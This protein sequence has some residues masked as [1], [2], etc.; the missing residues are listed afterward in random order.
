MNR[1]FQ[2]L[3]WLL[4]RSQTAL[5]AAMPRARREAQLESLP[6]SLCGAPA[7]GW[8]FTTDMRDGVQEIEGSAVCAAH[9]R[10]TIRKVAG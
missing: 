7:T 1:M 9:Q 10:E 3:D 2:G 4:R 6:C 8:I 5:D